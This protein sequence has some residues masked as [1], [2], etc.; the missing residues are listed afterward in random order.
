MVN[1]RARAALLRQEEEAAWEQARTAVRPA[2]A[3]VV[4]PCIG[5]R[6]LQ[7]VVCP[8]FSEAA[9]WEVR[10]LEQ[11]WTL[12]RSRVVAR[13]PDVHLLG[14]DPVRIGPEVLSSFFTRVTELTL[15]IA[16]DL[17]GMVGL[18]GTVT[19]LAVFG[20]MWT[21]W[22]FQWWSQSPPQW[23][24]LVGLADEMAKAFSDADPLPSTQP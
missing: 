3:D 12:Y 14:Y 13:R 6:R 9:A 1:K 11:Q 8:P 23:Q 15:P 21:G 20:D 18:D 10:Q 7:L 4:A 22:R 2:T 19:H 5:M 17:S 16:P 24:S